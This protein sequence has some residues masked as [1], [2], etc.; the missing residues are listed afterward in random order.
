MTVYLSHNYS[1][2]KWLR[3]SVTPRLRALGC[4]VTSRWISDH[5]ESAS[6]NALADISDLDSAAVVLVFADQFGQ[7]PGRGKYFEFGYAVA[8]GKRIIVIGREPYMV[9]Y[10]LPGVTVVPDLDAAIRVLRS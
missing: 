2:R 6:E 5:F 7:R 4:R 8:R 3:E 9:F 10:D 1:A